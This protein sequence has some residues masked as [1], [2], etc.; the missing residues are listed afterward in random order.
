[1]E[2]KRL[3]VI[4]AVAAG[5]KAASKAK[6]ENPD[7]EVIVFTRDKDISYAGCGLPYYVGDV[8]KERRELVVRGPEEFKEDQDIVILTRREATRIN[9]GDKTV[10]FREMD[11]G[12]EHLINYDYLVLATG[13]SPYFPPLAGMDLKNIFPLRTVED[14]DNIK[15]ILEN[16]QVK[17]AV[18]AGGGFIGLEAAENLT[19]RGIDVTVVEAMPLILPGYDEEIS[20]YVRNY[21][22]EKGITVKTGVCV[23]EFLPD[24]EGR[25]KSVVMDN[26]Q[27]LEAQLVIWAGG[28]RPNT[29]LAGQAGITL[30]P[31]GAIAVNKYME[32]N[33]SGIYAVG[34]CAENINLITAEPAW[35]PMGST[36]NKT[37]R[38]A[39]SNLGRDEREDYLPGVLGTSIIKLFELQAAR[40]GL[41]EQQARD[42]GYD[43]ISVLVP[44]DDRAHYYPGYR[45]IITKLIADKRNLRILGAQIVGEG[46]VDKPIDII[47]TLITCQANLEQMSRLDLAYAPPFSMAISSTILS[48]NVLLNKIRGRVKGINP[49]ELQ[50][51]LEK[52]QAVLV[53]VRAEVE[54]MIKA[55]PG[56]LNIPHEQLHYRYKELPRD[57]TLVVVCRLGRRA[58]TSY[59]KLKKLGFSNVL[60]LEGGIDAYP[61][62]LE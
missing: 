12:V 49:R 22:E 16:G 39:G 14:A 59:L 45:Q 61:Y 36:A 50:P 29:A 48:A 52:G 35:F 51:L 1:M 26:G 24:G 58:Y 13:A 38:I 6:R 8:I 32:T 47:A 60:I 55:I 57:K 2:K 30:G 20:L 43:A 11:T 5:T 3:V 18:V 46:V 40:T 42:K 44:A 4:G 28:V 54:N 53:D 33:L 25:V 10:A 41:T 34:D 17:E 9:P 7:W 56:S 23:R 62:T 27:N 19:A 21:L 31:T 15:K 37:G